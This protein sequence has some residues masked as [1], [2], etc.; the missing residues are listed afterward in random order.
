MVLSVKRDPGGDTKHRGRHRAGVSQRAAL[1]VG[2]TVTDGRMSGPRGLPE[3]LPCMT[4]AVLV[5]CPCQIWGSGSRAKS[6]G[7]FAL[8]RLT[9]EGW[10]WTI[11]LTGQD[12]THSDGQVVP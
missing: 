7:F 8:L 4:G 2:V 9:R 1:N 6:L 10:R 12:E 3:G 5:T 11:C